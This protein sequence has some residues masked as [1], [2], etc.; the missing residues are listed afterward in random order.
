[1]QG[2]GGMADIIAEVYLNAEL[3][4]LKDRDKKTE[5]VFTK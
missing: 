1:M 4:T 3:E 2:S 5:K